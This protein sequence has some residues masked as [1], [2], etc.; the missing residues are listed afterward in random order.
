MSLQ[1][2]NIQKSMSLQLHLQS[3]ETNA[4]WQLNFELCSLVAYFSQEKEQW[5]NGQ[6]E[7]EL[8]LA[9]TQFSTHKNMPL[10]QTKCQGP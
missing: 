6:Q 5:G 7:I 2:I 4:M 10:M 3:Y 8:L 9:L 1:R